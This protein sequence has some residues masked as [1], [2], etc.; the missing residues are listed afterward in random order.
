MNQAHL[1]LVVNHFPI[2]IPIIGLIIMILGFF[3]RS[4]VIKRVAFF[5]FILGAISILPAFITGE[6]AEEVADE[7]EGISKRFMEDH[8]DAAKKFA[9]LSYSLGLLSLAGLWASWRQKIYAGLIAI[10]SIILV[11][12]VLVL[13]KQT[14]TTGGEIR[15]TE[16]RKDAIKS[17]NQE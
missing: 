9:L 4:D 8:E 17:N 14:G 16:I 15:H 6:G 12:G 1:H 10:I 7:I 5:I 11:A 3:F 13:G 2:I